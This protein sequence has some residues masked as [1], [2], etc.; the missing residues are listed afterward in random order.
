[1]LARKTYWQL[2]PGDEIKTPV[3]PA[4]VALAEE[5]PEEGVS[6]PYEE[7]LLRRGSPKP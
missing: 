4:V 2:Q 6:L 1:M 5:L 3:G 7:E